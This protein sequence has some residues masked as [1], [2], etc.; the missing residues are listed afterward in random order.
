MQNYLS[1]KSSLIILYTMIMLERFSFYGLRSIVVLYAISSE[2]LNL[3][4]ELSLDYYHI[5]MHAVYLLPLPI[6]ILDFGL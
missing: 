6:G 4:T 1:R 5:S 3:S 2:G